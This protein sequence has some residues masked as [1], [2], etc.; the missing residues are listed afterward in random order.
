MKRNGFSLIE[1]LAVMALIGILAGLGTVSF[2]GWASRHE[3]E[4]QVKEIYADLASAR[5]AAMRENRSYFVRGAA[6]QLQAYR[7][8]SPDPHGDGA[9]TVGSDKAVCMWPRGAD[10]AA[11]ANCPSGGLS[12][13]NLTYGLSWSGSSNTIQFTARGLASP[14]SLGT[15]CVFSTVNPS[16]DCIKVSR[17]R[18][19]LGKIA[20]QGGGCVRDNCQEK[21]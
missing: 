16:Y 21:R 10:V 12:Y 19:I 3:V 18:I 15:A 20:N 7:D 14:D 13:K 1:L 17:T 9:L 4:K 6:N 2:R 8:T 5:I 11:D